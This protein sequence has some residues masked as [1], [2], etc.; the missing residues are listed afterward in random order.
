MRSWKQCRIV[1]AVFKWLLQNLNSFYRTGNW[2]LCLHCSATLL[3]SV[4]IINQSILCSTIQQSAE[5]ED[6]QHFVSRNPWTVGTAIHQIAIITYFTKFIWHILC[7]SICSIMNWGNHSHIIGIQS[8]K[9]T[10]YWSHPLPIL[11]ILH[12]VWI[13]LLYQGVMKTY[14]CKQYWVIVLQSNIR[15]LVT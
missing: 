15:C 13:I 5:Y 2:G 12:R 10:L 14:Y 1:I 4:K 8:S 11:H 3:I 9:C 6:S 7:C